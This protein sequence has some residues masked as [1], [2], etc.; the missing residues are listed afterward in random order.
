MIDIDLSILWE[1]KKL[2]KEYTKKIRLEY[3]IYSDKEYSKWRLAFLESFIWKRI[4]MT[5]YFYNKYE[6]KAQNNL[7]EEK[8]GLN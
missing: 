7:D 2:Y 1:D 8:S 6:D 3:S 5:D 4:F